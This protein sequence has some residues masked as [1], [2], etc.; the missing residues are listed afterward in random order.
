MSAPTAVDLLVRAIS[1]LE[2]ASQNFREISRTSKAAAQ[3]LEQRAQ[4]LNGMLQREEPPNE[5]P[6]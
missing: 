5:K 1:E 4:M 2:K 3:A 6:K